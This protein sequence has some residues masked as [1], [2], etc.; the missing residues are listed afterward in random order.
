MEKTWKPMVAGILDIVS[1]AFGLF[2]SI[3]LI[4]GGSITAVVPDVPNFVPALLMGLAV[5]FAIVA[6]LAIV[7]GVYALNRKN[8]GLALAGSIGALFPSWP[9]GI[10]AIVF[11]VMSKNEFE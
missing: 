10:A 8:L 11:T 7:G 5:P 9:L 2:G 1:G 6:I 3:G 4:I